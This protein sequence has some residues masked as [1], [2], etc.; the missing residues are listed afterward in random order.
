MK[1]RAF[2]RGM[3]GMG[4]AGG[5]LLLRGPLSLSTAHALQPGATP[6][7]VVLFQRGGCDGLNAV[8]PFGD[9]DYYGLR[10]TIGIAEP[11]P[12]DPEAALPLD[13]PLGRYPDFFGLHPALA[14]LHSIYGAG[15]LAV[16]PAVQYPASSHSHFD[17]QNFI[18]SGAPLKGLDGWLNRHL[19]SLPDR[20]PL[21]AVHFGSSLSQALRGAIPVQSFSSIDAFNLGLPGDEEQALGDTVLP[22]YQAT[23]SPATAYEQLV[24]Q[25]G[26]TLFDNLGVV[27]NI[28][29]AGYRPANGA[30]YPSGSYGRRLRETA[31]LIKEGVGLRAVTI[32][33]GGWDTHSDQGGGH[34]DGRQARRFREFSTGIEALY[35]DLGD[36]MENVVILTMTEFGRTAKENGSRGTDHGDAASWFVIHRGLQGG[37]YGDWP[38]L[39]DDQLTRGRYLRFTVDYRD[40]FG[41][42]LT[43]HMGNSHEELATLLPGH[44]YRPLGL[45]A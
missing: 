14:P 2:L 4:I 8:V 30:A 35:T 16:L 27:R 38:G 23:P 45:F 43:A 15:D 41:E 26:Q 31:Q 36:Q 34:A 33:I 12:G 29:T 13:D 44:D 5:G 21:Q 42:L 40:I 10:P 18:E 20:A 28:D 24:H 25:Y 9:P 1:R 32:D 17:S 11:D 39:A 3:L 7:L 19:A 22:V 37:I 6:T